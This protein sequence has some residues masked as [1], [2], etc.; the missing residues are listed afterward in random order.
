MLLPFGSEQLPDGSGVRDIEPMLLSKT[1]E[2]L[3]GAMPL[4][5][6]QAADEMR[7]RVNEPIGPRGYA[8][9]GLLVMGVA[10]WLT[11]SGVQL[12]GWL[13]GLARWLWP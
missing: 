5:P 2:L 13:R 9:L 4:D 3:C 8:F 7:R 1:D 12:F 11:L 10:C 6:K